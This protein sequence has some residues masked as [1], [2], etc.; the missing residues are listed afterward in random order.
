M[1]DLLDTIARDQFYSALYLYFIPC[2]GSG[3]ALILVGWIRIRKFALGMWIRI[4]RAKKDPQ[5]LEKGRNFMFQV[6]DVLL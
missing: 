5:K 4:R 6:L 3:T 2:C 1:P